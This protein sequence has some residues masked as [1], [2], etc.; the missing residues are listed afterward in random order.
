[1]S[2]HEPPCAGCAGAPTSG[3]VVEVAELTRR[4]FLSLSAAGAALALLVSACGDGQIG[5]ASPTDPGG[6]TGSTSGALVVSLSAFPALAAVGGA[7]RVDG[8]TRKPIALVR[9]GSATFVALSMACP[10]QGTTVRIQ[11]GGFYCPNHGARFALGGQ[12]N[13]GQRTSSLR[14]YPTTYDAAAGTVTIG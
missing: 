3:T 11:G 5:V 12:W 13:G 10:H 7:A 9:T 1:M 4:G 6:G 2:A 14:S 8:N